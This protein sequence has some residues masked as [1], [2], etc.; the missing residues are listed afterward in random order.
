MHVTRAVKKQVSN[1]FLAEEYQDDQSF[2]KEEITEKEEKPEK[3]ETTE[4]EEETTDD[5]PKMILEDMN[6]QTSTALVQND[7]PDYIKNKGRKYSMSGVIRI[8]FI[9]YIVLVWLEHEPVNSVSF[10]FLAPWNMLLS[11]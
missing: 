4:K 9:S 5:E 6:T 11:N 3:D 7:D 1:F 2:E 8:I 10:M